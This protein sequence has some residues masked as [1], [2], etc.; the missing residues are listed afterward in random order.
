[1]LFIKEANNMN[2]E[3]LLS[4]TKG[5]EN[6]TLFLDKSKTS[7]EL[8]YTNDTVANVRNYPSFKDYAKHEVALVQSSN[9]GLIVTIKK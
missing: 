6:I 5:N 1:M 8:V 9:F 3:S 4:V 7:A 2:L